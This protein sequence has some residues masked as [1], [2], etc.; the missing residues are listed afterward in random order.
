MRR[1]KTYATTLRTRACTSSSALVV[2]KGRWNSI[3]WQAHS[4]SMAMTYSTLL[5]TCKACASKSESWQTSGNAQH[6]HKARS[7]VVF[8]MSMSWNLFLRLSHCR[9]L[10]AIYWLF[11]ARDLGDART[12]HTSSSAISDT[13]ISNDISDKV[14]QCDA[15][16]RRWAR[17]LS[18]L[19]HC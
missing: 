8:R 4:N 14:L 12:K 7:I 18:Q 3:P 10:Y 6:L 19:R 5:T 11:S 2:R 1:S 17:S 16:E 15:N 13:I 9:V